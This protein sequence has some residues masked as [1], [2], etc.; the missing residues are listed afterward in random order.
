MLSRWSTWR[1]GRCLESLLWKLSYAPSRLLA[2]TTTNLRH[3]KRLTILPENASNSANQG[4]VVVDGHRTVP[5]RCRGLTLLA[6]TQTHRDTL[7]MLRPIDC[8]PLCFLLLIVLLIFEEDWLW[9]IPCLILTIVFAPELKPLV[10]KLIALTVVNSQHHWWVNLFGF[11]V[12]ATGVLVSYVS[13][14]LDLL[15]LKG[16]RVHVFSLLRDAFNRK[17]LLLLL[18]LLQVLVW[19]DLPPS[20]VF[21][22][23]LAF[24]SHLRVVERKRRIMHRHLGRH[25]GHL[26]LLVGMHICNINDIK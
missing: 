12:L 20:I 2:T 6:N 15:G 7:G 9:V 16:G 10:N 21:L 19:G 22:H 17:T 23:P 13:F 3:S 25:R 18:V 1:Q 11:Y 24:I 8:S 14:P 5:A 26:V 4:L